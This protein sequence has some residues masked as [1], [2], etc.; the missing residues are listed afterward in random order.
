[1]TRLT[2]F[3]VPVLVTLSI[4]AVAQ[5][6]GPTAKSGVASA[7][8]AQWSTYRDPAGFSVAVPAGWRVNFDKQAGRVSIQGGVGEQAVIWPAFLEQQQLDARAAGAL[9]Q[10]LALKLDP[11][12]AWSAP[13]TSANIARVTARTGP[14]HGAALLSWSNSANGATLCVYSLSAPANVYRVSV[15][16]FT[17]IVKSFHIEPAATDTGAPAGRV[18]VAFAVPASYVR[19][20]EPHE[21]AFTLSV[22]Q[23]WK[24]NGGIYRL[25]ANDIR[26]GVNL[27]SPDGQV[28]ILIGDANIPMFG[29]PTP[30][31]NRLGMREGSFLPPASDGTRVQIRRYL[32]G[33]QFAREYV[34]SKLRRECG[35][36]KITSNNNRPDLVR[37]VPP[38]ESGRGIGH[39]ETTAGD[40][41][42]SCV[43]NG[44]PVEGYLAS[45]TRVGYS[46]MR[47]AGGTWGLERLF[48]DFAPSEHSQEARSIVEKIA[49]SF[50]I[51]PAWEARTKQIANSAVRRDDALSQ[52]IQQRA[53]QGIQDDQRQISDMVANRPSSFNYEN[54]RK[55][56]NATLGTLDVVDPET[57]TQYKVSNYSS[58]HFMSPG[59]TI[60][61]N[62]TGS[63][64]AGTRA[65][66]T[67][68]Y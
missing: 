32:S 23:G 49:A 26:Q 34:E 36:L 6:A 21:N 17:K 44:H 55:F 10:Q 63:A 68:P 27:V 41:T 16:S 58:Y 8:P 47:G 60:S 18:A 31:S 38:P 30:M 7:S 19:W 52:Q 15:D 40:A 20:M 1:M 25:T 65:L 51:N 48:A 67:L 66:V 29:L 22:P 4:T 2:L 37:L 42:F 57:G 13:E 46:P 33:Q 14:R 3:S 56:S 39:S 5:Q 28:R 9:V 54:A 50:Q 12:M 45:I 62:E 24:V 11:Q 59:G 61:G 35:D 64:P 53:L 43:V